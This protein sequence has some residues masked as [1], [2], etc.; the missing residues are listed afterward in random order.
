MGFSDAE[1]TQE[2]YNGFEALERIQKRRKVR[3]IDWPDGQCVYEEPIYRQLVNNYGGMVSP[4]IFLDADAI[5][6]DYDPDWDEP[7]ELDDRVEPEPALAS[8]ESEADRMFKFF[9]GPGNPKSGCDCGAQYTKEPHLENCPAN[10][11]GWWGDVFFKL[12]KRGD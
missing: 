4:D 10:R 1:A 3:R 8:E 7:E 12:A 2:V 6:E 11:W 9:R 5:W